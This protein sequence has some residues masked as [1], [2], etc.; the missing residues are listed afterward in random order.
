MIGVLLLAG[1]GLLV[2]GAELLVRGAVRVAAAAG[3]SSLV[4][5]LTVVAFGTSAPELAVSVKA[6]LAGQVDIA[7]GNVVGSNIL[8]VLLILGLSALIVPLSVA[9]QLLR[10]DVPVMIGVSAVTFVLALNG[11]ISRI[12]GFVLFA[13]LVTYLVWLIRAGRREESAGSLTAEEEAKRGPHPGSWWVVNLLLIVGGLGLLVL[14][15]RLMVD[16]GV[17]LARMFGVSELIIG[18]TVIAAGTSLP[19]GATSIVAALRGERDIAVGNAVGSNL[20]NL[21]GVL[22]VTAFASPSGVGVAPAALHFDLP[23]MLGVAVICLP[24]FFTGRTISRSEGALLLTCYLAYLTYLLLDATGHS[25]LPLFSAAMLWC[26]LPLTVVGLGL[27]VWR[28]LCPSTAH[29]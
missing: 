4:I 27:S 28:A 21:L 6:S 3:F 23:V 29:P 8:N 22:G 12:E 18:L 9:R 5:G 16:G 25:V 10:F 13:G 17:L 20:F 1:F 15:A 14:G 7:L 19:E 26:A 2:V 11:R 24:I